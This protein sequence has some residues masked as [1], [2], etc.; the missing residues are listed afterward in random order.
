MQ[1]IQQ[2]HIPHPSCQRGFRRHLV[3]PTVHR[4]HRQ[5]EAHQSQ[6]KLEVSSRS[7]GAKTPG[8]SGGV[9]EGAGDKRIIPE[10][11]GFDKHLEIT[12]GANRSRCCELPE[13]H[14]QRFHA[15]QRGPG[16]T[17]AEE[18]QGLIQ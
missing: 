16:S 4:E 14:R 17:A 10:P 2:L 13:R 3:H 5:I 9:E 7:A 6:E 8:R 18:Y 12:I 11:G 1:F 15:A